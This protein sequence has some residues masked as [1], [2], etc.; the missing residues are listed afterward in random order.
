M[1]PFVFAS[2]WIGVCSTWVTVCGVGER[3]QAQRVDDVY[4]W[5]H[6]FMHIGLHVSMCA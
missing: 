6:M 2:V 5:L 1:R 4:T 3:K